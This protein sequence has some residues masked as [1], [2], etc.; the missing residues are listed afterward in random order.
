MEAR[1][2]IGEDTLWFV[3]HDGRQLG[4]FVTNDLAKRINH[5][6]LP[7]SIHVWAQGFDDWKPIANVPGFDSYR[8]DVQSFEFAQ[9]AEAAEAAKSAKSLDKLNHDF[10]MAGTEFQEAAEIKSNQSEIKPNSLKQEAIEIAMWKRRQSAITQ[11]ANERIIETKDD[12]RNRIFSWVSG[13]RFITATASLLILMG[14]GLALQSFDGSRE[15]NRQELSPDDFHNLKA[16]ML[17]SLTFSGPSASIAVATTSIAAPQFIIGTNLNDGAKITVKIDGVPESMV[18]RF[19]YSMKTTVT[20][21]SGVAKT[22]RLRENTKEAGAFLP[23]LYKVTLY[24]DADQTVLHQRTFF[25]GSIGNGDFD[26]ALQS[27][28]E[29]LREQAGAEIL[30]ARQLI[31]TISK[32]LNESNSWFSSVEKSIGGMAKPSRTKIWDT[33]NTK[34]QALDVQMASIESQWKSG[35]MNNQI[36]HSELFSKVSVLLQH[37]RSVHQIQGEILLGAKNVQTDV[38]DAT[39]RLAQTNYQAQLAVDSATKYL[40]SIPENLVQKGLPFKPAP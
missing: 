19:Y 33:Q 25:L 26:Q 1:F 27:Y 3:F 20:V 5:G 6:E 18:G 29:K 15:L 16:S 7:E 39:R 31:D 8:I 28:H 13:H 4:P 23:G 9:S 22:G 35:P 32:V 30:E 36:Y 11:E 2:P 37:I 14:S 34:F 38:Q 10:E 40:K 12:L 24:S 21:K 17:E